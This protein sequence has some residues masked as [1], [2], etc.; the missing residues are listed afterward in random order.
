VTTISNLV[1]DVD[2]CLLFRRMV[3]CDEDFVSSIAPPPPLVQG[4]LPLKIYNTIFDIVR[5]L[6][7]K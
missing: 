5:F 6:R 1:S 7:Y 2:V 4:I 3:F